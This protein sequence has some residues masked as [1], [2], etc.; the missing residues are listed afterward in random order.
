MPTAPM[1]PQITPPQ[2]QQIKNLMNQVRAAASPQYAL[3]QLMANNPQLKTVIN[4]IQ[5]N[6]GNAQN[7]FYALANQMGVDPNMILNALK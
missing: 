2:I 3:N 1:Q 4:L 5:Q 6:G 7:T